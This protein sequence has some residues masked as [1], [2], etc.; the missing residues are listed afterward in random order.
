MS[1]MEVLNAL[2]K[3]NKPKKWAFTPGKT[4]LEAITI[5]P[6]AA[7]QFQLEEQQISDDGVARFFGDQQEVEAT[8]SRGSSSQGSR[9]PPL[10]LIHIPS[11]DAKFR[12]LVDETTVKK[13]LQACRLDACAADMLLRNAAG[14]HCFRGS[15]G[16][17]NF[18]LND[19]HHKVVWTWDP[20]TAATRALV[21]NNR[22][23]NWKRFRGLLQRQRDHCVSP[24]LLTWIAALDRFVWLEQSLSQSLLEVLAIEKTTAY[25]AFYWSSKARLTD[26]T[27]GR[28]ASSSSLAEQSRLA[29]VVHGRITSCQWKLTYLCTNL[30]ILEQHESHACMADLADQTRDAVAAKARAL[31]CAASLLLSQ[32]VEFKAQFEM[33]KS[34]ANTQFTVVSIDMALT[35]L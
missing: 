22:P 17:W 27:N 12:L 4:T 25:S 14:F 35:P 34:R 13:A 26:D 5:S 2:A 32:A 18:S 3:S 7:G 15:T 20:A 8:S 30:G 21:V 10:R 1:E 11:T 9:P 29:G 6:D 16:L 31:A 28:D 33:G 23:S 19:R 24:L